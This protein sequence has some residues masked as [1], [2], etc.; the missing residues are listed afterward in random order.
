MPH[1]IIVTALSQLKEQ[2]DFP[3]SVG[4]LT[5]HFVQQMRMSPYHYARRGTF[6]GMLAT[7]LVQM[8]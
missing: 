1:V 2:I 7:Q 4:G 6:N 8:D 5:T 3:N